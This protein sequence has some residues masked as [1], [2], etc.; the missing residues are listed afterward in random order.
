MVFQ[1]NERIKKA[2]GGASLCAL[3]GL[4][5]LL[6]IYIPHRMPPS[7]SLTQAAEEP[8]EHPLSRKVRQAYPVFGAG[9]SGLTVD[10]MD[11]EGQGPWTDW[12]T[13]RPCSRTCGGGV[14]I[15]TR[16]CA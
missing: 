1:R 15:Q 10:S 12:E 4:L 7:V 16:T 9:E 8:V 3:L 2:T 11:Q 14:Q 13:V 6:A 5:S